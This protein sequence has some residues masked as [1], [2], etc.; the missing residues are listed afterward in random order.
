MLALPFTATAGSMD[1]VGSVSAVLKSAQGASPAVSGAYQRYASRDREGPVAYNLN[2]PNGC[3][4]TFQTPLSG[5]SVSVI[6][7]FARNRTNA[8]TIK[9][10]PPATQ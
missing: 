10:T 4:L 5:L 2:S 7:K 8:T 9:Q 3:G 6:T 1:A